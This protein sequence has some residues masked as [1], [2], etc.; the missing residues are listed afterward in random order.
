MSSVCIFSYEHFFIIY[1]IILTHSLTHTQPHPIKWQHMFPN[2]QLR[3]LRPSSFLNLF[4]SIFTDTNLTQNFRL[5]T[6]SPCY[7][8][9]IRP[10]F[11]TV[12]VFCTSILCPIIPLLF[13]KSYRLK[14]Y[15]SPV[16]LSYTTSV[17]PRSTTSRSIRW[18]G[19]RKRVWI[20]LVDPRKPVN[21]R[22]HLLIKQFDNVRFVPRNSIQ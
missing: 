9:S 15:S 18:Y 6:K 17:R 10:V 4:R 8:I 12:L 11:F 19:L 1:N 16:S 2:Y 21:S 13:I 3:V 5:I 7:L 14:F 22:S 20:P